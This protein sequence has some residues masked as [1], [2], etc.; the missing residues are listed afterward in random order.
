MTNSGKLTGKH[1][2]AMLIAF[3]GVMIIAMPLLSWLR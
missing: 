1:V 2:L 3:F